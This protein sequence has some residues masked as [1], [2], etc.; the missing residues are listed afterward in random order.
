MRCIR[1]LV[2]L[3]LCVVILTGC[4]CKHQ[5]A[6]ATCLTPKTCTLCE[7]TEGEPA[8][9]S[10]TAAT[11]ETPKTCTVC[12]ATEGDPLGHIEAVRDCAIDYTALTMEQQTYCT[13]CDQIF[14]T[15]EIVLD[16]LHDDTHFL[17]DSQGFLER[18]TAIEKPLQVLMIPDYDFAVAV[19]EATGYTLVLELSNRYGYSLRVSFTFRDLTEGNGEEAVPRCTGI[20][21]D[22]AVSGELGESDPDGIL[23]SAETPTEQAEA[24]RLNDLANTVAMNDLMFRNLMVG[25]MVLDPSLETDRAGMETWAVLLDIL[26]VLDGENPGF[27]LNGIYYYAN[28]N[29]ELVMEVAS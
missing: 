10:W 27:I 9:H 23:D 17:I 14:S 3:M 4:A 18:Y 25:F 26:D 1:I 2:V 15:E 12:A 16:V 29:G 13:N 28:E 19:V 8:G 22:P 24:D 5:W 21:V 11:C 20:I 7:E 6:D